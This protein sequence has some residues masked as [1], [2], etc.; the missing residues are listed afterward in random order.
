MA[1]RMYTFQGAQL[2][3]EVELY[4]KA[5]GFQIILQG[6]DVARDFHTFSN[7]LKTKYSYL[8]NSACILFS[9]PYFI[10]V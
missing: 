6:D 5:S 4:P 3:N 2:G 10:I 7:I 8:G 1:T 9:F